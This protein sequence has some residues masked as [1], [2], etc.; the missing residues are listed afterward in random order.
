M[1]NVEELEFGDLSSNY[2]L[3]SLESLTRNRVILR[4]NSNI[5]IP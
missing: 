3:S 4:N 1:D 5:F 2:D